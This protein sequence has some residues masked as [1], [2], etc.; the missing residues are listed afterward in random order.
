MKIKVSDIQKLA[1]DSKRKYDEAVRVATANGSF[2]PEVG[3][4]GSGGDSLSYDV[5]YYEGRL[6]ALGEIYNLIRRQK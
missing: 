5:G 6:N 4:L 1:R 2:D 3:G